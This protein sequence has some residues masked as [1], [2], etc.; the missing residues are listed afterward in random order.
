MSKQASEKLRELVGDHYHGLITVETYREERRQLLN[1]I[2]GFEV[3]TDETVRTRK[4]P[5]EDPPPAT[6]TTVVKEPP[7]PP[8]AEAKKG[9]TAGVL[10]AVAVVA[11]AGL[12]AFVYLSGGGDDDPSTPAEARVPADDGAVAAI[13]RGDAII[14]EFL[15]RNDWSGDGLANLEIAWGALDDEQRDSASNGRNYRRLSTRLHQRIREELA[16]GSDSSPRLDSLVSLAATIGAPYTDALASESTADDTP[17][18]F[19]EIKTPED[20][21]PASTALAETTSDLAEE[22]VEDGAQ[23]VEASMADA[24]GPGADVS[25]EVEPGPTEQAPQQAPV[26]TEAAE[27]ACPASLANSR[28][29]TCRDP[30]ASGGEGPL[31]VVVPA[32]SFLM[33]SERRP[34]E[35]PVRQVNIEQPIAVSRFEI[36]NADFNQ[37]CVSMNVRCPDSPWSDDEMPVVQ[38]S[39]QEATNYAEWLSLETGHVY[40]LPTE[41]EWEYAARAGSEEPYYFG[42]EITPVDAHSSANGEVDAPVGVA[43]RTIK[44][45]AFRLYHMSGNVREWV[46]DPWRENYRVPGSPDTQDRAVRGGSFADEAA[47]LRSAA[48]RPLPID[49]RDDYTGFRIVREV[50]HSNQ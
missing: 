35:Q 33:G 27:D 21:Q 25:E 41:E 47:E 8:A 49:H 24:E 22:T 23:P 12:G 15:S 48:R 36:T 34:E 7:P 28:R 43:R 38:V 2:A 18:F 19:E 3:P 45:N 32:G 16:L 42:R 30:F 10:V 20:A 14:Q 26:S 46:R 4:E 40:R 37:Y 1:D 13:D 6:D 44:G 17:D 11:A 50:S 31:M 29:S 9:G 39:W 5:V